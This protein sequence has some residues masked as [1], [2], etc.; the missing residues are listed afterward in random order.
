MIER[1]AVQCTG[2]RPFDVLLQVTGVMGAIRDLCL[3][4]RADA[5]DT[6]LLK[7]LD[8]AGFSQR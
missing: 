5:V 8:V 4:V 3:A 7:W 6:V 1:G 2:V